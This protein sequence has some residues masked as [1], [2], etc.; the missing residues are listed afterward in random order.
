MIFYFEFWL[1][2]CLFAGLPRKL[3]E[4]GRRARMVRCDRVAELVGA[5]VDDGQYGDRMMLG[6]SACK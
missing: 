2:D 6:R 4:G 5:T 3:G 1:G